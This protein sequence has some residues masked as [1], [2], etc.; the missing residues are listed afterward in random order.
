MKVLMIDSTNE[1]LYS[2]VRINVSEIA[3]YWGVD[4]DTTAIMFRNGQIFE[5]KIN[6]SDFDLKL[7]RITTFV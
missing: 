6:I 7:T 5:Y 2:K 3:A 4:K 1:N